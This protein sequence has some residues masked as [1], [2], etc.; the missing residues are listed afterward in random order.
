MLMLKEGLVGK[1]NMIWQVGQD[2]TSPVFRRD[3]VTCDFSQTQNILRC[4]ELKESRERAKQDNS[5]TL[6]MWKN[7]ES[8]TRQRQV[9][10]PFNRS[11][12][13]LQW[14]GTIITSFE[15][16]P[17]VYV[18]PYTE[19]NIIKDHLSKYNVFQN[20]VRTVWGMWGSHMGVKVMMN[21]FVCMLPC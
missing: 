9:H 10:T 8:P 1:L 21:V 20:M 12:G 15:V 13:I 7:P 18:N 11:G 5:P 4:L 3:T 17:Q 6:C 16:L 2:Y 14:G 19:D